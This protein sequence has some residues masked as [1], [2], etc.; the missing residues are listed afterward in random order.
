MFSAI[1]NLHSWLEA[2]LQ[3]AEVVGPVW[4]LIAAGEI[5]V[6]LTLWRSGFSIRRFPDFFFAALARLRG[7]LRRD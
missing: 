4:L 2:L 7:L 5:L 3:A 1:S 6:W